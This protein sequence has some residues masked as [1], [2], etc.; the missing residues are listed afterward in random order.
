MN[1]QNDSISSLNKGGFLETKNQSEYSLTIVNACQS[2]TTLNLNAYY[3]KN[4]NFARNKGILWL[5]VVYKQ[6]K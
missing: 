2:K 3:S 1:Y 4:L 5:S 6:N